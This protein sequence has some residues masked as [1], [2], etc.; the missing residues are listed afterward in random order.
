MPWTVVQQKR[1]TERLMAALRE[2]EPVS[3]ADAMSYQ[4]G[5]PVPKKGE[6]GLRKGQRYLLKDF[7]G[8]LK[9]GEMMLVV[10]RPGS[11]CTTFLKS[12]AGLTSS[13]AGTEGAV[14]YG[15]L[16]A[17]SKEMR[18]YRADV[19]FN[20]EEDLHDPN[21]LVGQ[22]M[23]FALR[24]ETPAPSARPLGED[25]KPMSAKEYQDKTKQDLLRAFNIE[26]TLNTKV[27]DQYVRGVSGGERKRVSLA[28]VLTTNAQ[29]QCWDNATRGLDA[30]TAFAFARVCRTLCDVMNRI[31]V[32]SL[33][34]AGN[35]I[36][37]QF[38]K[39]T[40]IAEGRL[41]YY[42]PRAEARPYFEALGFEHME[43]ANTADYLT[44]VT[45]LNE[46]QIAPGFEGRVPSTPAEFARIYQNS[47]IARRMRAEV[48]TYLADKP[49]REA[50]TAGMR[51]WDA[52]VKERGTI[53][54]LP[55]KVSFLH[56]IKAAAIKDAQQRW[57]DQWSLWARQGTTLIQALFNGSVYYAIPKTTAG[58]FLRGGL[59]FMLVLFPIILS[60]ADVQ[61]AFVGRSVLAKHKGYSMYRCV[62]R[63]LLVFG[64]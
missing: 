47:D 64:G 58:I 36:Y 57:G 10:G 62:G 30:S 9:P 44:A 3:D 5:M 13:Y 29:I 24:N 51:E 34:Q 46:R 26:H 8:L 14:Y 35:S 4:K 11:G 54:M 18:P 60:F 61:S 50:E 53:K 45:A 20:S 38:D 56:Q 22:T 16:K 39:V 33:Y 15:D 27:G 48:D 1:R 31:N 37:D 28:E 52:L 32:V 2:K 17:G 41:L 7:T 23:D 49:K 21:L 59:L 25:G 19:S 43:G 12:L 40:V 6:P 55:Q 63:A 42:G